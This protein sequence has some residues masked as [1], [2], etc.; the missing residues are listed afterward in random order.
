[1]K[2]MKIKAVVLTNGE[3]YLVHGDSE[4][5]PADMFAMASKLWTLDPSKESV[6]YVEIE[7]NIPEQAHW[8]DAN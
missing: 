6:H 8:H 3:K 2:T 5:T 1:M 7:I 4:T